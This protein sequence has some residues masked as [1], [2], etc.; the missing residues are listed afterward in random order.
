MIY[1]FSKKIS[2]FTL[3][4]LFSFFFSSALMADGR[5]YEEMPYQG[6]PQH[7][8]GAPQQ[9]QGAPQ[10]YQGGYTQSNLP[11][12]EPLSVALRSTDYRTKTGT[13]FS[14]LGILTGLGATIYS[15]MDFVDETNKEVPGS[16]FF[17]AIILPM[18]FFYFSLYLW[19]QS[20]TTDNEWIVLNQYS[21][22]FVDD[23]G[24]NICVFY[25]N[26]D[27]ISM[28]NTKYELYIYTKDGKVYLINALRLRYYKKL[29]SDIIP[30][31]QK[32][33]VFLR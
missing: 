26:I 23:H 8:Q 15:I 25:N 24:K 30:Y 21:L 22:N 16:I 14:L 5:V 18:S 27:Y 28:N 10:Q 2:F 32:N 6:A 20:K 9:Y 19:N 29:A 12:M 7:Y 4:S 33:R 11:Y 17:L 13:F 3:A 1:N 31:L